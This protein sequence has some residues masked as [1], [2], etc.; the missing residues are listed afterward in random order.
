MSDIK[1]YIGDESV[2][3]PEKADRRRE[4]AD[5][6]ESAAEGIAAQEGLSLTPEHWDVLHFLREHYVEHGPTPARE[7]TRRLEERYA[8]RGGL[9]HLYTLF[10]G[11]P[12]HQG[13]R[14]AGVPEPEG[15]VDRSFGSV[16]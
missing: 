12:V 15:A 9:R 16:R 11:G 13:S 6:S 7:L 2:D 8:G 3:D 5:W 4:L 1:Q 14:I 10:P